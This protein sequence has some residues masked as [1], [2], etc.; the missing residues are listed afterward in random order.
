M[1]ETK[2]RADRKKKFGQLL[3]KHVDVKLK[4][5]TSLTAKKLASLVD[6][7]PQQFHDNMAGRTLFTIDTIKKLIGVLGLNDQE[8]YKFV[9]AWFDAK[10]LDTHVDALD[11]L[12]RLSKNALQG[13]SKYHFLDLAEHENEIEDFLRENVKVLGDEKL[14]GALANPACLKALSTIVDLPI[15]KQKTMFELLETI[16]ARPEKLDSIL[17]VLK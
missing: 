1:K 12:K 10:L 16:G 6:C 17:G 13:E 3:K 8:A 2:K 5:D 11:Y 9:S 4:K 15:D 7:F 14:P